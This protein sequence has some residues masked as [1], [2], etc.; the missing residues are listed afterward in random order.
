MRRFG[1]FEMKILFAV[2]LSSLAAGAVLAQEPPKPK[3]PTEAQKAETKETGQDL[4]DIMVAT[5]M[6]HLKLSY[7]GTNENWPL[8][9][10][11]V[12]RIRKSFDTA[13]KFYPVY[14]E[15]PVADLI[16][17]F[18]EPPLAEAS[19]AIAEKNSTAFLKAFGKLTEAC[20]ACHQTA[21]VRFIR[22]KAP[23]ASPFSNQ[24]FA[25]EPK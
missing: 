7:A 23:T 11:E 18:S 9:A 21:G 1:G 14:G 8:A 10:F 4:A 24:V 12:G 5:Q 6:R 22:I 19:K 16:A 3:P 13:K 2:A 20:N 15:V 17:K 25:P